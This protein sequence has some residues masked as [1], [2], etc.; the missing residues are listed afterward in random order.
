MRARSHP[1]FDP[2]P[3]PATLRVPLTVRG[4]EAPAIRPVGTR[5]GAGGRLVESAAQ[6]DHWPLAPV[7]AA[8]AGP[9]RVVL[10]NGREAAAVEVVT[11]DPAAP[12]TPTPVDFSGPVPADDDR[13]GWIDRLRAMGLWVDRWTSPNL[14]AQLH[15]SLRRPI[16]TVV[17]SV[18]DGDP[19]LPIGAAVASQET[20]NLIAGVRLIAKI[21]NAAKAIVVLQ[22]RLLPDVVAA[23]KSAGGMTPL[24]IVNDYPQADPSILLATVLRRKLRPGRLPTDQGVVL[25]DAIAAVAVG[26]IAALSQPMLTVPV[27]LFNHARNSTHLQV[28]PIGASLDDVL[29]ARQIAAGGHIFRGGDVLRNNRIPR[30]AVL[31]GGEVALHASPGPTPVNPDPCIRCGWCVEACPSLIHPA[32]LLDSAQR[33]D[34]AAAE[35]FGLSACVEC[36]LCDYVCPSRLPILNGIRGMRKEEGKG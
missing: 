6:L 1:S 35:H 10:T 16:D 19:N 13:G 32:G 12:D 9:A 11:L 24:E 5:V 18:L 25:L 22:R 7:A 36:G 20:D 14:L 28:A 15:E 29:G 33:R 30:S 2:L 3:T 26:R 27:A 23:I 31:G 8:I 21:A 34:P 17:C 4:G